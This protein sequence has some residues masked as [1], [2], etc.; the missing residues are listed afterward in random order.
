MADI[1][2]IYNVELAWLQLENDKWGKEAGVTNFDLL[3]LEDYTL[4]GIVYQD[5]AAR[6]FVF[7]V[8]IPD[9][10][11]YLTA[12]DLVGRNHFAPITYGATKR[13]CGGE[14]VYY[15]GM[16]YNLKTGLEAAGINV[17][18]ITEKVM[19]SEE[20]DAYID[21]VAECQDE[22]DEDSGSISGSYYYTLFTDEYFEK[23]IHN[24]VAYYEQTKDDPLEGYLK[25]LEAGLC[26]E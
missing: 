11:F 12:L 23:M 1:M 24:I 8:C 5:G 6:K 13:S 14:D 17:M 25:D 16:M 20:L 2:K 18:R 7:G 21:E 15:G 22:L 26:G 4:L 3:M 9:I 10:G 19:S